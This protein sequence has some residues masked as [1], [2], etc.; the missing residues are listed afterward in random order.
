M[1]GFPP[2]KNSAFVWYFVIRDAD[3]DLVA[4]A[5][6]L[7]AEVSIDGGLFNDITAAEVDE[8]QG[9]YSV[10]LTAAEMNGDVIALICKTGTA[11]AKSAAQIVY[12]STLQLTDTLTANPATGGIAAG[13][14]ADRKTT[15]L[16]YN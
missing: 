1:A 8:G 11:G 10:A 3:G 5:S 2:K 13:S 4:S 9:F 15:R 12:T 14:F 7:D 16:N 6:A